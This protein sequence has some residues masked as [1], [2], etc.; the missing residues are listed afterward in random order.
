[1]HAL[2]YTSWLPPLIWMGVLFHVLT[3]PVEVEPTPWL[4]PHFDKV[5]HFV[6]FAVLAWLL[7]LPFTLS[8]SWTLP[9]SALNGFLIATSYGA[10]TEYIQSTI[11]HRH[12]TVSDAIAN[13]LGAATVFAAVRFAPRLYRLLG[14][15]QR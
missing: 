4:P 15:L 7:V 3:M 5:V 14:S 11:P 1:M 12:G 10:W 6:L 8:L 9:V 13:M 2:R